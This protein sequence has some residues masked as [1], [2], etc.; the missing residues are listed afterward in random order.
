MFH[1]LSNYKTFFLYLYQPRGLEISAPI[2]DDDLKCLIKEEASQQANNVT[3]QLNRPRPRPWLEKSEVSEMIRKAEKRF[4][5]IGTF[6]HNRRS[7]AAPTLNRFDGI[8]FHLKK[9]GKLWKVLNGF[10]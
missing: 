7:E 8:R 5:R 2:S 10:H 3:D 1:F 9:R 6:V 4:S